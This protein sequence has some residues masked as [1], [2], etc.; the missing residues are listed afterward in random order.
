MIVPGL[1]MLLLSIGFFALELP[2]GLILVFHILYFLV[3]LI[4]YRSQFEY[5]WR[6]SSLYGGITL[7]IVVTTSI[8]FA[9]FINA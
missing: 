9:M 7:A 6:R 1:I 8:P 5:S 4:M 3:P 2:Q